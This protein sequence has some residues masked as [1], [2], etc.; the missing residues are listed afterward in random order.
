MKKIPFDQVRFFTSA[1]DHL[2]ELKT[3]DNDPMLEVALAGRSNVGKS[4]LINHLFCQKKLAKVS[5]TPG[6]TRLINFFIVDEKLALVDLPGYG[7]AKRS[8]KEQEK[9]AA[10][11]ENYFQNRKTLAL[12]LLLIDIRREATEEDIA[13]IKWAEHYKKHLLIIFTKSD[14]LSNHERKS[15][16][17]HPSIYYSIKDPKSRKI[18]IDKV[19]SLCH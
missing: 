17:P 12:I 3:K 13:L 1:L 11:L 18:L 19:N 9:W 16:S 7:F 8:K 6:K 14:T 5:S 10:A 2:P 4:S 15:I